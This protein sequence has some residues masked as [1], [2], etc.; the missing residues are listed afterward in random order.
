MAKRR[1]LSIPIIETDKFYK[2]TAS[3]QALYLHLNLNADDDGIVD[4]VSLV[5]GQMKLTRRYYKELVS[6]GYLLEL[7]D[8]LVAITHWH[9]HNKIRKDRYTAGEYQEIISGLSLQENG[10]YTKGKEDFLVDKCVPQDRIGK[11]RLV[12]VSTDKG[13]T[14]KLRAD[15]EREEKINL[16]FFHTYTHSEPASQE[17]NKNV[18]NLPLNSMEIQNLKNNI[19]LYFM[20]KYKTMDTFGFI[21]HCEAN[22]WLGDDGR[23][24][25][26]NLTECIKRYMEDKI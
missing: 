26:E 23:Q 18:E 17:A 8:G 22:N 24:V 9:Q 11:D 19:R 15:E 1:M 21:E 13:S 6:G 10:R 2:L 25:A 3:A 12:K 4:K 7:D 20:K 16:S 14:A 5:V